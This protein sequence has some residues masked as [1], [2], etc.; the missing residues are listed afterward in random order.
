M[1]PPR[2]KKRRVAKPQLGPLRDDHLNKAKTAAILISI[3]A[4]SV[5]IAAAILLS[6]RYAVERADDYS[7]W[8]IDQV[9]GRLWICGVSPAKGNGC[10]RIPTERAKPR[11]VS[12]EH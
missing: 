1:P 7:A 2:E 9:T 6:D 12:A 3:I 10:V 8:L 5:I 4:S 11:N